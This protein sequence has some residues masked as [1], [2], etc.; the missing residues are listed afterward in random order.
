MSVMLKTTKSAS[1]SSICLH[2]VTQHASFSSGMFIFSWLELQKQQLREGVNHSFQSG[3]VQSFTERF[4]GEMELLYD[5][6]HWFTRTSSAP[7]AKISP[8]HTLFICFP[9]ICHQR[10]A[11]PQQCQRKRERVNIYTTYLYYCKWCHPPVFLKQGLVRVY[12]S[13]LMIC[14]VSHHTQP[15]E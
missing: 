7:L 9:V 6:M 2:F 13:A 15:L 11:W 1:V 8:N 14:P 3:W 12:V 4:W 5:I 10:K